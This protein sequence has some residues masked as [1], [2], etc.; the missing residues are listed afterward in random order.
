MNRTASPYRNSLSLLGSHFPR[1]SPLEEDYL[2]FYHENCMESLA[3]LFL[4]EKACELHGVK[5][6]EVV[7]AENSPGFL[8]EIMHPQDIERSDEALYGLVRQGDDQHRLTYFVRLKL[9]HNNEYKL[10]FTCA[11]LNLE[12]RRFQCLTT[13]LEDERDFSQE[14]KQLLSSSEY[15]TRHVGIY[16]SLSPRERE[17][18]TLVCQGKSTLEIA[19]ELFRSRHTIEKHKKNIFRKTGFQSNSELIRF[20][21]CFNLI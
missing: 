17:I 3:L 14:V 13:C 4:D 9:L 6:S 21:L 8:N 1:E 18:I 7:G 15:I 16:S 20:A 2:G 10:Y 12:R 5:M 19:E 11:R